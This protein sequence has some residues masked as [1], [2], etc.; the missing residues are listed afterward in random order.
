MSKI[1][2]SQRKPGVI[3]STTREL[4]IA[5][6]SSV[7]TTDTKFD[8]NYVPIN[9][10]VND[11]VSVQDE[12]AVHVQFL[13]RE[14]DSDRKSSYI[15]APSGT[16]GAE[17]ARTNGYNTGDLVF[18]NTARKNN[19]DPLNYVYAASYLQKDQ[20]F[21]TLLPKSAADR[22]WGILYDGLQFGT[23]TNFLSNVTLDWPLHRVLTTGFAHNTSIIDI[24]KN[25]VNLSSRDLTITTQLYDQL[26]H[27]Y[28]ND[29]P[30]ANDIHVNIDTDLNATALNVGFRGIVS[31]E[32]L[33]SYIESLSSSPGYKQLF[34]IDIK[35]GMLDFVNDSSLV[36]TK[37]E[38]LSAHNEKIYS[39]NQN[40]E[41]LAI[42]AKHIKAN[43]WY[44][45][46]TSF[47]TFDLTS[48]SNSVRWYI[49]TANPNADPIDSDHQH[50]YYTGTAFSTNF[51]DAKIY[52]FFEDAS[53]DKVNAELLAGQTCYIYTFKCVVLSQP[54][55]EYNSPTHY[56][57]INNNTDNTNRTYLT[58]YNGSTNEFY[59]GDPD[60]AN[61][62]QGDMS[63]WVNAP[64]DLTTIFALK[65]DAT[66]ENHR[67]FQYYKRT[68]KYALSRRDR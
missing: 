53:A 18:G 47:K 16:S 60:P 63:Q 27:P 40:I 33:D 61:Y 14:N 32:N 38:S 45:E 56:F 58:C 68:C 37:Y 44:I 43:T 39:F 21:K 19:F 26:S 66:D 24:T 22:N 12:Q 9:F 41:N 46:D 5:Q 20:A 42:K 52:H 4:S 51:N 30:F 10:Q 2:D 15:I 55:V 28:G 64:Y 11:I 25:Y 57:E 62:R 54:T 7:Y 13:L 50:N 23:N 31:G 48:G 8:F 59:I 6:K 65:I 29:Y 1:V 67:Y 34:A 17:K 35:G 49:S 3:I 36:F